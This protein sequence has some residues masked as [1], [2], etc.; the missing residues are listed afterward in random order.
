MAAA[1]ATNIATCFKSKNFSPFQESGVLAEGEKYQFLRE[2]D[3]KFVLAKKKGSG[4][5]TLQATKTGTMYPTL[6]RIRF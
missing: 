1:E 5:L 4:A 6:S 3:G 2:E